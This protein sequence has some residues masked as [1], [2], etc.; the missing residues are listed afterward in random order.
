MPSMLTTLSR[1]ANFFAGT[2]SSHRG[3]RLRGRPRRILAFSDVRAAST[4]VKDLE[5]VAERIQPDIIV[6][7]GDDVARFGAGVNSWSPLA[8]RTRFGL[9]GVLGNDCRRK[10][11]DVFQ[12]AGCHDLDASP[13]LF[14]DLAIIGLGG[15][16]HDEAIGLGLNLYSRDEARERLQRQVKAADGRKLLLVSHAPPHGVLDLAMR[17][18]VERIGSSVVREFL[19]HPNC[20]AV[21]CGH[22]HSRGGRVEHVDGRPVVNIASH[23]DALAALRFAVLDWDGKRFSIRT[24]VWRGAPES[25]QGIGRTRRRTVAKLAEAGFL[26]VNDVLAEDGRELAKLLRDR[27]RARRF[28]A[29]ARAI[30]TGEIVSL[31]AN[32]ALPPDPLVIDIETSGFN[33]ADPWLIGFKSADD[34]SVE[35]LVELD[36]RRHHRQLTLL[37]AHLKARRWSHLMQWTHFDRTTLAQT[38]RRFRLGAPAWLDGAM[39]FDACGWVR[40]NVALPSRGYQLRD[41]ATYFNFEY[42]HPELNGLIAGER[43]MSYCWFNVA[44]D[45]EQLKDYNADDV[46]AVEHVTQ[47]IQTLL[48]SGELVVEPEIP[49]R[50]RRPST[51]KRAPPKPPKRGR[52]RVHPTKRGE[53]DEER[54]RRLA[55]ERQAKRRGTAYRPLAAPERWQKRRNWKPP[56]N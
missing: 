54:T 33:T 12:Q 15:A 41:V 5:L 7:G 35:Q 53:T 14:D 24:E 13:L 11:A 31:G 28:R 45:V 42:R 23:D 55:R 26:T 51:T 46:L 25:L 47:S 22:V 43:Y 1:V 27:E 39:W 40:R 49:G 50:T 48:N 19:Q 17:F 20:R 56:E 16:P 8:Q 10:D 36:E 3:R 34:A 21:V 18:G 9:A 52:P 32:E 38:F 6:Y 37:S 30:A 29:R 2:P 4:T 44:F